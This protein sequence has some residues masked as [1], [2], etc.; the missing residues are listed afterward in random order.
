MVPLCCL[1][2]PARTISYQ[3]IL[4]HHRRSEKVMFFA[5][6]RGDVSFHHYYFCYLC[7]KWCHYTAFTITISY[8]FSVLLLLL[9]HHYHSSWLIPSCLP[10]S[11]K[12]HHCHPK[13]H[14]CL[15]PHTL[16]PFVRTSKSKGIQISEQKQ[17]TVT[18]C[19]FLEKKDDEK[20]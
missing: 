12:H 9:P 14:S 8:L 19:K 5:V 18:T 20:H 7:G 4:C 3:I 11:P 1:R 15:S 2:T 13:S 16:I 10:N 6:V 17:T